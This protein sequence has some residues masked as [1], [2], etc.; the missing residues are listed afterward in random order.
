MFRQKISG[1]DTSLSILIFHEVPYPH[2]DRHLSGAERGIRGIYSYK[3]LT[4]ANP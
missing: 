3:F 4:D 2:R 1:G